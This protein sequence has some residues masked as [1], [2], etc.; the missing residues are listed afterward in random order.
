MFF[1][2]IF[3]FDV[4]SDSCVFVTDTVSILNLIFFLL[5][6]QTALRNE[7]PNLNNY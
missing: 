6:L 7:S 5:I 2:N 4:F 1:D 3:Y